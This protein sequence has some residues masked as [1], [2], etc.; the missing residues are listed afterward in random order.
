VTQFDPAKW[1]LFFPFCVFERKIFLYFMIV[2]VE[3]N[4][5]QKPYSEGLLSMSSSISELSTVLARAASSAG[6]KLVDLSMRAGL[7]RPT[8][9]KAL[10]GTEDYRVSTL[11]ALADRLGLEVALVPK[12]LAAGIGSKTA[13]AYVPSV[14]DIA[15]G[16]AV[17]GLSTVAFV[18]TPLASQAPGRKKP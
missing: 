13:A 17:P 16:D 18:P 6:I 12:G 11:L 3:S 4:M 15:L 9:R 7:S 1:N 2:S 10:A 5:I 8:T 14:V